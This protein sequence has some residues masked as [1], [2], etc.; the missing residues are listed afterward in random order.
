MGDRYFM[1]NMAGSNGAQ[2]L[3]RIFAQHI[4]ETITDQQVERVVSP[5]L[6]MVR[7]GRF[8]VR[9]RSPFKLPH[10]MAATAKAAVATVNNAR[11]YRKIC[12]EHNKRILLTSKA[13][14]RI[15][16]DV[17]LSHHTMMPAKNA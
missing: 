15:L 12:W 10:L 1:Q 13:I 16:Y 17:S 5:V 11:K 9:R 7:Q 14:S 2:V 3:E 6:A 4:E 8:E